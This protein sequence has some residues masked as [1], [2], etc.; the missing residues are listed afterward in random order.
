MFIKFCIHFTYPTVRSSLASHRKILTLRCFHLAS[1][2]TANCIMNKDTISK[3]SPDVGLN[4]LMGHTSMY[5]TCLLLHSIMFF[6]SKVCSRI[7]SRFSTHMEIKFLSN[8]WKFLHKHRFFFI[9]RV[10]HRI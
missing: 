10:S 9:L 8:L 1:I 6:F 7:K 2:I 4:I 3:G 5:F